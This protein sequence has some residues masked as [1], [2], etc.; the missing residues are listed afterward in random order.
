MFVKFLETIYEETLNFSD[1]EYVTSNKY[2]TETLKFQEEL[3]T[4][5]NESNENT[6]LGGMAGN[7]KQ[8]M[9]NI[10]EIYLL[11]MGYCYLP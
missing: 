5:I 2:F 11:S 4:M 7:M 6:L 3:S 9:T 10:G 1:S 8:N